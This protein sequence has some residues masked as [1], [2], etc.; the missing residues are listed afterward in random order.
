M[1]LR[2][3]LFMLLKAEGSAGAASIV[4]FGLAIGLTYLAGVPYAWANLIGVVS[5]GVTNCTVNMRYVFADSPRSRRGIIWR[6]LLVWFG[7]M[8]FNGLGTNAVTSL[9][10]A[11]WFV[12]V[13]SCVALVV[14][15]SFNYP[16]QRR[17]V[18]KSRQ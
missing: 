11:Q 8:C 14:A 16:M 5:G 7:S 15:L 12:V 1:N 17:F 18:F 13:K 10:G 2:H 4:D 3:E 6:Y 9:V